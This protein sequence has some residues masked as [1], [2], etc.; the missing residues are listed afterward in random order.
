M[1]VFAGGWRFF[2]GCKQMST[3]QKA[4]KPHPFG[5]GGGP[6]P[7]SYEKTAVLKFILVGCGS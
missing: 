6:P 4:G 2:G 1:G 3:K 7:E 5:R